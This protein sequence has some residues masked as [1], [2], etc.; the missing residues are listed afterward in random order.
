MTRVGYDFGKQQFKLLKVAPKFFLHPNVDS[1]FSEEGGVVL[2]WAKEAKFM[3]RF[4][5]HERQ[6]RRDSEGERERA[7]IIH[8]YAGNLKGFAQMNGVTI[9]AAAARLKV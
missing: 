8:N 4:L 3:F 6:R 7:I 5:T 2:L 9:A 1:C